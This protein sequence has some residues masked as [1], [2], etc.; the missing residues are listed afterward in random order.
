MSF[1]DFLGDI[2]FWGLLIVIPTAAAFLVMVVVHW[3]GT[4]TATM[5]EKALERKGDQKHHD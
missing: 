1:W 2:E 3:T 5:L 4:R